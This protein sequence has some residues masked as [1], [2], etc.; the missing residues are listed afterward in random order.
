MTMLSI[1]GLCS[2][3]G[4]I[5]VLHDVG[6]TI[7]RGQIVTLI[8]A[9]GAGKTTLLKT[10]SGLIRPTAGTIAFEGKSIARRPPHRIVGLGLSQVPEGRAILKRMTVLDNLRMGAFTRRDREVNA[11]IDAVFVRFPALAERRDNM[12][13]TLS[14]GEQQML[15]I[16]RALVARP[17]LLL[18]DE[19][20]LGLAP[21]F[22]TRIFLT[23][24]ELQKEGKTIL[25]VEQNARQALQVADRGYVM[26]RGRIVLTGA[27][28]ELLQM[29]EVQR[30]YLGQNDDAKPRPT[31]GNGG[32][33]VRH[34][35]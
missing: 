32:T 20:S 26:E 8:G 19:P 14:G 13:G 35:A 11:D 34:S 31:R 30:T 2:G 33:S 29:P 22:I 18:L 1:A 17:T 21:K 10:I 9:N 25:L 7:E 6:L 3:Y 16:G 27:G 23:L 28:R 5:A 12:A 15:A 24:R 4:K